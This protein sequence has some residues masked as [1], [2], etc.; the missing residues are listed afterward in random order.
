MQIIAAL[1]DDP[2]TI[3]IVNSIEGAHAFG[4]TLRDEQG[5][6]VSLRQRRTTLPV[7]RG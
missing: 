1:R 7:G 6:T 3:C 4:D 2:D 5:N